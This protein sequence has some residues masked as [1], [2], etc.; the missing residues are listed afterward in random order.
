M[1]RC[2]LRF[3]CECA[4][5]ERDLR[6]QW[7]WRAL[8]ARDLVAD[9]EGRVA[10]LLQWVFT[11]GYEANVAERD[12]IALRVKE[13]EP[14]LD[15]YRRQLS[16]MRDFNKL[17]GRMA[18]SRGEK[19]L[20]LVALDELPL[21]ARIAELAESA[22]LATLKTRRTLEFFTLHRGKFAADYISS[23]FLLCLGDRALLRLCERLLWEDLKTEELRA[24]GWPHFLTPPSPE[25]YCDLLVKI[26]GRYCL[27]P[28]VKFDELAAL[29]GAPEGPVIRVWDRRWHLFFSCGLILSVSVGQYESYYEKYQIE[30]RGESM[31]ITS[32]HTLIAH[33][34][35]NDFLPAARHCVACDA[36]SVEADF[37]RCARCRAVH[38]CSK[39]CQR[40][41]WVGGHKKVCRAPRV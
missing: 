30:W 21:A 40:E 26:E 17:Q 33:L 24:Q 5:C 20:L 15:W 1:Q 14:T 27:S 8:C 11:L 31:T 9:L 18:E 2:A 25:R 19:E 41:D 29:V 35:C 7:L 28:P 39:E 10:H 23:R 32:L 6:R 38:Y 37:L 4:E 34:R 13:R 12:A 36:L 3:R 16:A 22:R